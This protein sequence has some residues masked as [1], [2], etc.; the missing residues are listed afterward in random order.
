MLNDPAAAPNVDNAAAVEPPAKDATL[1]TGGDGGADPSLTAG[2]TPTLPHAWMQGMTTEQKADEKLIEAVSKF[3]KG[4]PDLV[5][6][7]SEL[8]TK[9][10]QSVVFPNE[11]ATEEEK[12]QYRKAIGVPETKEDYK[13]EKGKLPGDLEYD[14][15]MEKAFR[16]IAHKEGY[17]NAQA[18]ALFG[19][20]T[21]KLAQD[22]VDARKIIKTTQAEVEQ[23]LRNELKGEYEPTKA[24]MDRAVEKF[25]GPDIKALL[26]QSGLGN[27]PGFFKMFAAIGKAISEHPFVD[28]SRGGSATGGQVGQR[29][30]DEIAEAVYPE[31]KQQ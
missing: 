7:Y 13:L 19:W 24:F 15:D 5:K 12:V 20:W 30:F 21:A 11:Q 17:T 6:S 4:I 23:Q 1:L 18:N 31:E 14:E 29:S 26:V 22:I 3:E 16:E 10:S 25:C 8:E 27:Y 9:L 2:D 28:G